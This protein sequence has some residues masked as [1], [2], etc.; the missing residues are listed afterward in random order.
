MN[1]NIYGKINRL[2]NKVGIKK[3]LILIHIQNSMSLNKGVHKENLSDNIFLWGMVLSMF[4]WGLSWASGKLLSRYASPNIIAFYRFTFTFIS[5]YFVVKWSKADFRIA[6][7]GYVSLLKAALVLALYSFLFFKGLSLGNA[8]AGGV[9]VTILNPIISYFIM[10]LLKKRIPDLKEFL[11]LFLGLIAGFVLLS[12]WSDWEKVFLAGNIYFL[13]ASFSWA[14]LSVFTSKSADYGSPLAF[15]FW[16]YGLSA[17]LSM[18][19]IDFSSAFSL[20]RS[21]DLTFWLNLFY[22]S[23]ITTAFATT[24]YFIATTKIGASKASSFIFLVPFSATL[25]AWFI[26]GEIPM[27]NTL[28][29][30]LIGILAVYVLNQKKKAY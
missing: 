2:D 3:S 29:G 16:M 24:F 12:L 26:L 23:T 28:L 20:L 21:A 30:G 4:V 7:S 22:S 11:G 25:G 15:S 14:I 27:W 18:I 19:F 8:G 6:R 13:L 5:M 17:L 9:L 10:L 1:K